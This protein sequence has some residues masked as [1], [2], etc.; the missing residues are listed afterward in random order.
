MG[1]LFCFVV[2]RVFLKYGWDIP[3]PEYR[4]ETR[5]IL[6]SSVGKSRLIYQTISQ[7]PDGVGLERIIFIIG[8]SSIIVRPTFI[9]VNG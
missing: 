6:Y 5:S 2:F 4:A 9:V 7:A 3:Y 1:S 8:S